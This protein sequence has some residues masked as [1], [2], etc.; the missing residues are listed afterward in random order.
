MAF[1]YEAEAPVWKFKQRYNHNWE[2]FPKKVCQKLEKLF[3]KTTTDMDT[4]NV[5]YE[6]DIKN[7]K[8]TIDVQKMVATNSGGYYRQHEVSREGYGYPTAGDQNKL[9]KMFKKYEDPDDDEC[10]S[11]KGLEKFLKDCKID[12]T[13]VDSL[14]VL[15]MMQ[16][17]SVF[18][19]EKECFVSG[20]AKCGC[21]THDSLKKRVK[22]IVPQLYARK[23]VMRMFVR[24]L[25]KSSKEDNQKAI[26]MPVAV[27]Y[28]NIILDEKR[29]PL[30]SHAVEYLQSEEVQKELGDSPGLHKDDF[31]MIFEFLGE[32][33]TL[34]TFDLDDDDSFWPTIIMNFAAW[35][36]KASTDEKE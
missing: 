18:E 11:E 34:D 31:E 4:S 22:E 29:H 24:W 26:P 30:R 15:G 1:Y 3:K 8:W 23:K 35:G 5:K 13:A 14:V 20:L 2:K 19:I 25:H 33:K 21:D 6:C 12:A 28:L 7:Q 17:R 32:N 9:K 16:L 36:K 27:Q 10:F